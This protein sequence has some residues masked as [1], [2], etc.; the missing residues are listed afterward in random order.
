MRY[1]D[2]QLKPKTTIGCY[3]RK[4]RAFFLTRVAGYKLPIEVRKKNIH[5]DT[6]QD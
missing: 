5:P 3:K 4:D 6:M 1:N 2:K